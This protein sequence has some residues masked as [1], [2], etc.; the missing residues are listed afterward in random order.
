[1]RL[2]DAAT[3]RLVRELRA[4]DESVSVF[5]VAFSPTDHRLLAVGYGGHV[6]V[7]YVALWD[8]DAGTEL[9]RYQE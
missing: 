5:S 1:M 6:D 2:C 7:S 9:V 8:I 4:G 3:G